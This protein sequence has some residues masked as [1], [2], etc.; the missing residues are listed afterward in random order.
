MMHAL[1]VLRD[2]GLRP[3][4]LTWRLPCSPRFYTVHRRGLASP[5]L[6]TAG[7]STPSWKN[8]T[9]GVLRRQ[10]AAIL[11]ATADATALFSRTSHRTHSTCCNLYY[12]T[13][14]ATT[15]TSAIDINCNLRRR[16]H[17]LTTNFLALD[18]CSKTFIV[19]HFISL[20]VTSSVLPR[21]WHTCLPLSVWDIITTLFTTVF[22][23][24]TLLGFITVS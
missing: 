6:Q 19:K 9:S 10:H 4:S 2:H 5:V 13:I 20:L 12:Q 8:L 14:P 16:L 7:A 11:F 24:S 23:V 15:T 21:V 3:S 22:S 1:R 17:I 18:R